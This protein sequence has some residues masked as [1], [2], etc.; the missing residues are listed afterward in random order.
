MTYS[1]LIVDGH[2][3][4]RARI[5]ALVAAVVSGG[6]FAG[7][8]TAKEAC[9]LVRSVSWGLALVDLQLP[10]RSGLAVIHAIAASGASTRIVAMST[11]PEAYE[12]LALKAGAHAFVAKEQ[13]STKLP[14]LLREPRGW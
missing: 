14:A 10:D 1:V 9:E 3:A 12:P 5:R 8:G 11:D 2:A 6:V 13:L 4:A 7:V